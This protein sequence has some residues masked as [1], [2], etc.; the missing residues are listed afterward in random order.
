MYILA[1]MPFDEDKVYLQF[2][3]DGEH[4]KASDIT[5]TKQEFADLVSGKDPWPDMKI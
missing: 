5:V 2:F 1:K 4:A 3:I